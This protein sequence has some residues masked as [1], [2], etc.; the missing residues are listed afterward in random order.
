MV[1]LT[2][3]NVDFE[4][5]KEDHQLN[6]IFRVSAASITTSFLSSQGLQLNTTHATDRFRHQE[7]QT[8]TLATPSPCVD[9]WDP[10]GGRIQQDRQN[11][12]AG[13]PPE[14]VEGKF[15]MCD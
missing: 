1:P 11:R 5:S 14:E 12:T 7:T 10:E 9:N 2:T 13:V 3:R 15:T 6:Q 8:Q 4:L